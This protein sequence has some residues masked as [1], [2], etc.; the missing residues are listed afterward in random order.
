MSIGRAGFAVGQGGRTVALEQALTTRAWRH[1][2]NGV[3]RTTS[4]GH[5]SVVVTPSATEQYLTVD[6]HL[7]TTTWRWSLKSLKLKPRVGVDGSIGFVDGHVL[8]GTTIAPAR[9]FDSAGKDVT[10]EG[11]RWS[12]HGDRLSLTVDDA[13]LP[14]PYVVDPAVA[15]SSSTSTGGSG[16][17][18]SLTVPAGTSPNDVL[19]AAFSTLAAPAINAVPAGWT[20]VKSAPNG[21]NLQTLVYWHQVGA[22]EPASYAWT[23]ASS[24][25]WTGGII[26]VTGLK[27]SAPVDATGTPGTAGNSKTASAPA[28]AA[29]TAKSLVISSFAV[30]SGNT[31]PGYVTTGATQIFQNHSG[32]AT[33]LSMA[34]AYAIQGGAGA[35]T[36]S[37]STC[38]CASK[39]ANV[40]VQTAFLLDTSAPVPA[41][42]TPTSTAGA[43]PKPSPE[44]SPSRTRRST[45]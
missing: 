41:F 23:L 10:P 27:G 6:R 13:G 39:A 20:L 7:G 38:G 40:G 33:S 15:Y 18:V 31:S 22:S 11:T 8:T 2:Q 37:S 45:W 16:T 26:A 25:Q 43:R 28:I 34:T 29:V 9:I 5:E 42:T 4:Y 36:A 1:F 12:L 14:L 17:S 19:L 35:S 30:A 24:Q 44:R 3:R 21:T 32:T